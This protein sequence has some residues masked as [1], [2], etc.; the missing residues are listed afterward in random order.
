MLPGWNS[1][2]SA[3]RY[4]DLFRE[5]G[6]TCLILGVTFEFIGLFVKKKKLKL[7]IEIIGIFFFLLLGG[8]E[9]VEFKYERQLANLI[10]AK[11]PEDKS[12]LEKDIIAKALSQIGVQ[13]VPQE[14]PEALLG[15][16]AIKFS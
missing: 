9:F 13:K 7:A 10:K 1:L 4:H 5:I 15:R 3:S 16:Q 11:Q 2:D 8:A 6:I 14:S 12:D